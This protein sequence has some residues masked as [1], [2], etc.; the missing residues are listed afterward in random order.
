MR[1]YC[2]LFDRN[3]IDRGLALYRSVERHCGD[4]WLHVLCLDTA[5][6]EALSAL[7]LTRV[8]LIPLAALESWDQ[9]LTRARNDRSAVEFYF[10]CKSVLLAYLLDRHPGIERLEYLDSDLYCFADPRPLQREYGASSVAISPHR[11]SAASAHLERYGKYN[12]GW[13][14]VAASAEGRRFIDWWRA[15]CLKS[16]R[17]TFEDE[18][19]GDQKYLDEVPGLF[20]G[21][22]PVAHPGL[23]AGPWNVGERDVKVS[24]RGVTLDG[25]PL[26]LFHFHGLKRMFFNRYETGLFAFGAQLSPP[27]ENGIYRPY[28]RELAACTERL[29]ALPAALRARLADGRRRLGPRDALM[30]LAR[31]VR[32]VARRSTISAAA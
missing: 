20:P 7:A 29:S 9:G 11:F 2:T 18:R 1:H 13:V 21:A 16:C 23:N 26:Y 15:S 8:D 31:T 4:F 25:V 30:E 17:T 28:A 5:T 14:S 19:F 27:V 6:H 12:A 24:E 32:G 3:Y 10:T 22:V